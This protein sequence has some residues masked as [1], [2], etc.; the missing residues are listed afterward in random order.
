MVRSV[1]GL[2]TKALN[3]CL[4]RLLHF[5]LVSKESFPEVPPRVEYSMTS[6]GDRLLAIFDAM[7]Q[8][9]NDL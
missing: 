9:E 8:L 4:R 3:E 2:S 7:D 5:E 1:E 6:K